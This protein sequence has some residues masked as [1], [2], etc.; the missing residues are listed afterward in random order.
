[1][2]FSIDRDTRAG[3]PSSLDGPRRVGSLDGIR[4]IAVILILAVHFPGLELLPQTSVVS[5]WLAGFM[6]WG[7]CGVNLFLVLSGFL[8]TGI[9]LDTKNAEKRFQSFYIRRILRTFPL[10]YAVVLSSLA[11]GLLMRHSAWNHILG[12]SPIG[13]IAFLLYV[14][15]WWMPFGD[16][17]QM[18]FLGPLWSL[19]VEEQFYLMWPLCVW[20]LSTKALT[21]IR[22]FLF[23]RKQTHKIIRITR[24][25]LLIPFKFG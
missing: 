5:R 10:Y 12:P 4:G 20:G 22:I 18:T 21:K 25:H 15:N 14:Q 23:C 8:I 13:W 6:S 16:L 7:W 9:L 3:V 1:M 24:P 19:A 17:H 2:H 11:A